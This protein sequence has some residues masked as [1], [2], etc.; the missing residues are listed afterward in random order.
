MDHPSQ[1]HRQGLDL[2]VAAEH[3][4]LDAPVPSCPGWV[5][6]KLV[7]HA[8][9]ALERTHLVVRDQRAEFPPKADYRP[10]ARDGALFDQYRR[11][12][13]ETV[14][15]LAAADPAGFSWNFTGEDQTNAFWSRRMV[16]EITVHRYD[17]QLAADDPRPVDTEWA[18]D[19]I[20]EL[21]VALL[22]R[23][24]HR[25][26]SRLSASYHFHCT[27]AEGEWLVVLSD[28][29]PVTTREHAKGDVAVRGPASPLFL[30]ICGRVGLDAEGLD[31]FG[32]TDLIEAWSSLSF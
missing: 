11:I 5:V 25:S 13:D 14:E 4:G 22:P 29:H 2:L 24:T 17:A 16:H 31:A 30:W 19:G 1:L 10:L 26:E 6:G 15:T 3:A 32:D 23:I 18:V 8:A 7:N 20:D 9:R 12:L 21:V 28:G 27:D